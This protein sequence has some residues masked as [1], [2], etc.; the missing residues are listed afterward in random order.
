MIKTP[1][2]DYYTPQ[3]VLKTIVH[4]YDYPEEKYE[5]LQSTFGGVFVRLAEKQEKK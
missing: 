5:L 2:G 1:Q 3:E 4:Y